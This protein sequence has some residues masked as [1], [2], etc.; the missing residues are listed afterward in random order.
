MKW[1]YCCPNCQSQTFRVRSH[2]TPRYVCET[3]GNEF[4]EPLDKKQ[5]EA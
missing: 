3:C 4:D 1:R 2:S 5:M